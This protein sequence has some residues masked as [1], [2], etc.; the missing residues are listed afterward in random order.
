MLNV[1]Q[2]REL[3]QLK[4]D[5]VALRQRIEKLEKENEVLA[6]KAK[7][8][9]INKSLVQ[10]EMTIASL[11]RKIMLL[12]TNKSKGHYY[13]KPFIPMNCAEKA[14]TIRHTI[15][16]E[17]KIDVDVMMKRTRKRDVCFARHM[18][19]Y[20]I[21]LLTGMPYV[22]IAP[23]VGLKDHTSAIHSVQFVMRVMAAGSEAEKATIERILT[24][25][26]A[27]IEGCED[28][29]PLKVAV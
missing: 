14:E 29:N 2:T 16:Q 13:Q 26:R 24:K 1:T 28:L 19:A 18:T 21:K 6:T 10:M 17:T 23:M 5:N 7:K 15:T 25:C 4:Y 11:Q 22:D 27:Q 20:A 12:R 3:S 8:P 9:D